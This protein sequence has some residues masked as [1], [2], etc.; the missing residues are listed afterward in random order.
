[1][2]SERV[3]VMNNSTLVIHSYNR[4][5]MLRASVISA[6]AFGDG[7]SRFVVQDDC[8]NDPRTRVWLRSMS[9][10][11]LFELMESPVRVSIGE[12]YRWTADTCTDNETVIV[13]DGDSVLAPDALLTMIQVW[14]HWID[15]DKTQLGMLCA[16]TGRGHAPPKESSLLKD[17][18]DW[19]LWGGRKSDIQLVMFPSELMQRF[20]SAFRLNWFRPCEKYTMKLRKHGYQRR[21][22]IKPRI[23]TLHLGERGGD[24][25]NGKGH[26]YLSFWGGLGKL[27]PFP[28]LFDTV[29]CME[30]PNGTSM[31]LGTALM[32]RYLGE[33]E[34]Y[35]IENA[36][37]E[38]CLEL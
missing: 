36:D 38:A 1:L 15:S 34:Q 21:V 16:T 37:E 9:D 27:N 6:L 25:P 32:K 35:A 22:S 8:S 26:R 31:R 4:P 3:R 20:R 18:D 2:V 14:E 19:V 29:E 33:M 28:D 7:I 30:D 10:R 11:G 23:S 13:F 24:I 17:G 5:E 12:M